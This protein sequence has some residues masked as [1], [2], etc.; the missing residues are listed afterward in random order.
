MVNLKGLLTLALGGQRMNLIN[1]LT[2][3]GLI[4]AMGLGL[5]M[6]RRE[7][8]PDTPYWDLRF[9]VTLL[10]GLFFSPHAN[11]QDSLI[12]AVPTILLWAFLKKHGFSARLLESV[13]SVFYPMWLLD[14]FFWRP[15]LI[16]M[17]G[18]IALGIWMLR[19]LRQ[20]RTA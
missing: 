16:P 18:G 19:L 2:A 13:P 11:A 5:L 15:N 8:K 1:G 10:M 3:S 12:I 14:I 17:M 7:W 9:G 4:L 20:E 6:W